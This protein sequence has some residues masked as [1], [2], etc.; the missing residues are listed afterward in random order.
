MA[1][2]QHSQPQEM[3]RQRH[4]KVCQFCKDKVKFIDYKDVNR[5]RRF[6]NDRG[7]IIS[8]RTT[9]TCTGHQKILTRA[10]KQARSIALLPFIAL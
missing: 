8:R 5:I 2:Q 7:K 4:R 1:E 9:G 10:I 6:L 3:K